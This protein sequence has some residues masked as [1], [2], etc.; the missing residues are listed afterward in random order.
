MTGSNVNFHGLRSPIDQISRAR[1]SVPTNGLSGGTVYGWSPD[2]VG[3]MRSDL[4]EQRADVERA[5]FGVA[6]RSAVAEADVQHPVGTERQ[7]AAVVVGVRLIDVQQHPLRVAVER[8]VGTDGELGDHR[9]AVAVDVV[10]VG[11]RSPAGWKSSP[12]KP[13]LAVGLGEVGDVEHRRPAPARGVD[14]GDDAVLPD[15]VQRRI[16]G[17]PGEVDRCLDVGDGHELDLRVTDAR[18][19]SRRRVGRIGGG[20]LAAGGASVAVPAG[21]AEAVGVG[22]PGRC[23]SPERWPPHRPTSSSR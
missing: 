15:H 19:W 20:T 2:G 10:D 8:A 21:G 13:S 11:Q 5:A 4:A 12:S 16:A 3:S 17:T 14:G 9:V 1:P 22:G 18:R 6:A 23:R 7:I